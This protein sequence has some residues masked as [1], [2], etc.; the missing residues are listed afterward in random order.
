MNFFFSALF[1]SRKSILILGTL[2]VSALACGL[3]SASE[4]S[5][6]APET[7]APTRLPT[8]PP[9]AVPRVAMEPG[10][11]NPDEPVLISG[12]IPFTSPF[13]LDNIAEPYALLEDQAG[14]VH[15]DH[16]YVFPLD[17]QVIGPVEFID[18]QTLRYRLSLPS[19]PL[20]Q[21]VDVDNDTEVDPGVQVFA[22]AYWT[23]IWGDP[24]LEPRDGRG[25][26]TAHSSTITDPDQEGEIIGGFLVIWSPDDQQEFPSEFGNDGLLFTED[27]PVAPVPP[28]YSIVD[29]NSEPFKVFKEAEPRIDLVEGDLALNDYS[30]LSYEEAFEQLFEKASREYP[31]TEEKNIHWEALH[32]EFSERVARARSEIDFYRALRDF[33][34]R[35]PDGHVGLFPANSQAFF[36]ER[37]GSFGL[38]LAELSDGRVIVTDVLPDTPGDRAG[39]ELGAEIIEW[40]NLPI[41]EAIDRTQPFFGPY[42]T[43]HTERLAK[44]VFVTR[45]PPETPVNITFQNP[46]ASEPETIRL[47][48]DIEYESLFRSFPGFNRDELSLTIEGEVL[49]DSG[50][51]YI[52]ITSFR[53]DSNLAARLWELYIQRLIDNEIPGVII[54]MRENGGGFGALALDFAGFFFDREITLFQRSYYNEKKGQFEPL[55]LP[56]DLRPAPVQYEGKVAVLIGPDCLSACEGFAYAMSQGGR[57]L[58]VGHYPTAGAFGEVGRGQY[59]LPEGLSLQFPTGRPETADGQLVIEGI[60]IEPDIQVPVTVESALGEVDVVLQAAIEALQAEIGP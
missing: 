20:G 5:T 17:S 16:E 25:W 44:I 43:R 48:A 6:P 3:F 34:Y 38:R 51:G 10:S 53:G 9:T 52:Q 54:D 49:D 24:F 1:S 30:D 40:D 50:L 57:A 31:F 60:G 41:E 21:P 22:V 13:F 35:I 8:E 2:A 45:V 4:L 26:S 39:I 58:M 37:G 29:L 46:G 32:D 23:N 7:R 19:V 47:V 33:T 12:E 28:G 18:E 36:E 27:D 15:R 11:A 14:F 55:R 56:I 42:S 59:Q